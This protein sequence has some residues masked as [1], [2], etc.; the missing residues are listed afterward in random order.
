MDVS[1]YDLLST[2]V[3]LLD[4]Q[5][6][7]DHANTAAEELFGSSRRQLKGQLVADLLGDDETLHTR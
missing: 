5:G 6:R 4:A 1:A 3:L 7:I 2:A